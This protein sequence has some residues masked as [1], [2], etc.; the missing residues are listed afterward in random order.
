[1]L[2][3]DVRSVSTVPPLDMARDSARL[4]RTVIATGLRQQAAR[5][6]AYGVQPDLLIIGETVKLC[7]NYHAN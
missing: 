2:E 4:A 3:P 6:L 7:H 1:M 5:A